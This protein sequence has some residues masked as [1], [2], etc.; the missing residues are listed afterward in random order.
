M[1]PISLVANAIIIA[2]KIVPVAITEFVRLVLAGICSKV[3]VSLHAQP[4]SSRKTTRAKPALRSV[5]PA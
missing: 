4:G 1:E 3:V 2:P 5:G